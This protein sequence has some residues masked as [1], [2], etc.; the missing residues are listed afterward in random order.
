MVR[1]DFWANVHTM[2]TSDI[3]GDH[4]SLN[5]VGPYA[6]I[7]LSSADLPCAYLGDQWMY[8]APLAESL[9]WMQVSMQLFLDM[10][11]N[12]GAGEPCGSPTYYAAVAVAKDPQP[13]PESPNTFWQQVAHMAELLPAAAAHH[14]SQVWPATIWRLSCLHLMWHGLNGWPMSDC[15]KCRC[16][17]YPKALAACSGLSRTPYQVDLQLARQHPPA[18]SLA[19]LSVDKQLEGALE[20]DLCT[21]RTLSPGRETQPGKKGGNWERYHFKG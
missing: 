13:S 10:S 3:L 17:G 8:A 2:S 20:Q 21:L 14:Q 18:L 16:L 15:P 1:A 9:S 11:N 12:P 5:S 6:C 4:R 19:R 7:G